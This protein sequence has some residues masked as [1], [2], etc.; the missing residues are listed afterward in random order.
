MTDF[1]QFVQELRVAANPMA[2]H[3][4]RRSFRTKHSRTLA[5]LMVCLDEI[6]LIGANETHP[7]PPGNCD[8][9][10]VWLLA[11]MVVFVDGE[12]TRD[13]TEIRTPTGEA[14]SMGA[15]ANMCFDCYARH[16][17]GIGW[18]TGQLYVR[19]P[20]ER[21]Q[22]IAGGSPETPEALDE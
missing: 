22:S 18:G 6:G 11:E 8:L 3:E 20:D 13:R 2:S 4:Q 15:W 1:G 10:G 14:L 21:W 7:D 17:A 16:G 9:C 19:R 12:T 5:E